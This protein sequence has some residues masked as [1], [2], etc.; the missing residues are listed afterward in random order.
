MKSF[1]SSIKTNYPSFTLKWI[2]NYEVKEADRVVNNPISMWK[3]ITMYYIHE[4][5]LSTI[6]SHHFCVSV[7]RFIRK[8][9]KRKLMEPSLFFSTVMSLLHLIFQILLSNCPCA[10]GCGIELLFWL[11]LLYIVLQVYELL[12]IDLMGQ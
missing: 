5:N 7:F 11:Y 10:Y 8:Y 4:A 2:K 9:L 6:F 12:H 3:R 1:S